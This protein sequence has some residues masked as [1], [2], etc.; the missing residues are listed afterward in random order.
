MAQTPTR[1]RTAIRFEPGKSGNP[2]GR[3]RGVP[4]RRNQWR[5]VLAEH[6]P[7]MIDKLIGRAKAGDEFAI[8]LILERV[9]PPLRPQ[10]QSVVLPSLE[11]AE[12]IAAK[13]EA[14]L[15]A[16]GA[17][18]LSVD[19]GRNLLEAIATVAKIAEIN[20]LLKRVET[21]EQKKGNTP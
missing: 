16:L 12:G 14:V 3:P 10:S 21:L 1:P 17:G 7:E 19:T 20:D 4:D 9:A 11:I 8:K 2:K 5:E 6:L 13:A 18:Q 15:E